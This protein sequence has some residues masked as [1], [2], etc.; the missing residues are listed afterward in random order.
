MNRIK[1][2]G[3]TINI[4]P[5]KVNAIHANCFMSMRE[6][7]VLYDNLLAMFD[8][9]PDLLPKDIVV[10]TPDIESYEPYIHA[11]LPNR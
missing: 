1:T 2:Y 10:M 4:K 9:I 6:I 7:E 11:G 8:E 3:V 5:L